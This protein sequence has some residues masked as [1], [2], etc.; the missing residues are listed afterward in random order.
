MIAKL[1]LVEDSKSLI[2]QAHAAF[3]GGGY[4]VV[5]V[6]LQKANTSKYWR[7]VRIKPHD[8]IILDL[9]LEESGLRYSGLDVL[10]LFE[11]EKNQQ[12]TLR[13][14]EQVLVATSV[15]HQVDPEY[16]FPEIALAIG[17]TIYGL[18]KGVDPVTDKVTNYGK[19]LRDMVERI[20]AHQAIPLNE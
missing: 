16:V 11:Y 2:E 9:N 14:L 4:V 12:R 13:G 3:Q 17:F 1:Y 10:K 15:R 19:S 18:E 5:E 7:G 6:D 8:L 20:Y